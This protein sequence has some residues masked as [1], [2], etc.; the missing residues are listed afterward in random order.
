MPMPFTDIKIVGLDDAASGPSGQGA[1]V[2]LSLK[3]SDSAPSAWSQYF[4]EA[5]EQ[6]IYMMKRRASVFGDRLEIVCMPD[7]LQNDHLPELNNV[8]S[9]TNSEYR[10][11]A[12]AQDRQREIEVEI[13]RRQK[14][15]LANLKGR[16]KFD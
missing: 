7:E 15:E 14:D 16:L 6:H 9:E 12:D 3:L 11:Y 2:R 13:A 5:W 10:R 8:I 4:N 1:L